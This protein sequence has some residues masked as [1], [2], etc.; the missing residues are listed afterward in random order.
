MAVTLSM[1]TKTASYVFLNF[2]KAYLYSS[3]F[4]ISQLYSVLKRL[5]AATLL[6]D[7]CCRNNQILI[8][9]F[10]FGQNIR[11]KRA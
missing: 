3:I 10:F 2:E 8:S 1:L 6:D 9:S 7:S 5:I 11:E 4:A